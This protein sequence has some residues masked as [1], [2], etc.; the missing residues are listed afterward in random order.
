M[1]SQWHWV[2]IDQQIH[3]QIPTNNFNTHTCT[4]AHMHT[5]T[6]THKTDQYLLRQLCIEGSIF[7]KVV[8]SIPLGWKT[9]L[10]T[11]KRWR[12]H[13][14]KLKDDLHC[15]MYIWQDV[16]CTWIFVRYFSHS[17]VVSGNSTLIY[18]HGPGCCY[19]DKKW[20]EDQAQHMELTGWYSNNDFPSWNKELTYVLQNK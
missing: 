5:Y 9:R 15:Y 1:V 11:I 16:V 8:G 18:N 3:K 20:L 6:H 2:K 13:M 4:H 10:W 7:G 19:M 14:D 17:C 12:V